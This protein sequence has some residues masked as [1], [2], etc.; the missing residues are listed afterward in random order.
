MFLFTTTSLQCSSSWVCGWVKITHNSN[1]CKRHQHSWK[2][3]LEKLNHASHTQF[4]PKHKQISWAPNPI[5]EPYIKIS[6][7]KKSNTCAKKPEHQAAQ[8][9]AMP[10][11]APAR[12]QSQ[13]PSSPL[14]PI[15]VSSSSPAVRTELFSCK[16]TPR[17]ASLSP[18]IYNSFGKGMVCKPIG[19]RCHQTGNGPRPQATT[20]EDGRAQHNLTTI[21]L[22]QF[23]RHDD[24]AMQVC[25]HAQNSTTV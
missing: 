20:E 4:L 6:K 5:R 1:C 10:Q 24:N 25:L 15:P 21:K 12:L 22:F 13:I 7:S 11:Q 18:C 3:Y 17:S 23:L 9:L 19:P 14:P 2:P 8:M 16:R